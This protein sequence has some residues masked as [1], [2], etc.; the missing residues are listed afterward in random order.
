MVNFDAEVSKQA[1]KVAYVKGVTNMTIDDDKMKNRSKKCAEEG[2]S[3]SKGK[4]S[5]G[6]V[7]NCVNSMRTGICLASHITHFGQSA[8]DVTKINLLHLAGIPLIDN[9]NFGNALLGND[10]GYHESRLFVLLALV[11]L[12][13]LN[14]VK[15]GPSF[16]FKWGTTSYI[17]TK[18]QKVIPVNGLMAVD[19]ARKVG[20]LHDRPLSMTA[21][22]SGAGRV[23]FL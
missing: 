11:A 23:T 3:R 17:T 15:R 22:R 10:R 7:N 4:S 13:L 18:F 9:A 6:P 2:W 1:S 12:Q 20:I 5:F 16:P 21:D 8:L 19:G 14:T